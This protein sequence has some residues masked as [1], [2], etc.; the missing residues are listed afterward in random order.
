M[1]FVA[2]DA[3]KL[4]APERARLAS[5]WKTDFPTA[6]KG[7]WWWWFWLYF[8]ENPKDPK[9]PLQ[10]MVLWST[11]KERFMQVNSLPV[12]M[13]QRHAKTASGELANGAIAAWF[14]DG[15]QVRE[16]FLLDDGLLHLDA[17]R[18]RLESLTV[19]K[20]VFTQTGDRFDVVL[21]KPGT[22]FSF[23][24][25][26]S[27][28]AARP[29]A[30]TTEYF[31]RFSFFINKMYRLPCRAVLEENGKRQKF[32]GTSYFQM[33]RVQSPTVPWVWSL[34]HFK[35]G[36][37]LS[38]MS[39]RV[40]SGLFKED[41]HGL[42]ASANVVLRRKSEFFDARTKKWHLLRDLK[43][44]A[45]P[46]GGKLVWKMSAREGDKRLEAELESYGKATWR[47]GKPV[48]AP[49]KTALY[50]NEYM[51]V[52]TKFSFQEGSYQR[53]LAQVGPGM[54]NCEHAWGFLP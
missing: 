22:R 36:S 37:V 30:H 38:Y 26:L 2:N 32:T 6:K 51:V 48:L 34:V 46:Q 39:P 33:V 31:K 42:D 44:K 20:G 43:L 9:K 24:S 35:D 1:G 11:K 8:L 4:T 18:R 54:G 45:H 5:L 3:M 16:N 7:V 15:K 40:G 28:D 23:S 21:S 47:L 14:F 29:L 19:Q 52:A 25:K 27:G 53:T 17:K 13:E 10:L 12:N 50:Y 41:L 49:F